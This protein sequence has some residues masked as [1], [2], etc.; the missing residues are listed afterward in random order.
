MKG[1]EILRVC[2]KCLSQ[3]SL[4]E[5]YK[6]KKG[7]GGFSSHC[8]QCQKNYRRNPPKRQHLYNLKYYYGIGENEYDR[9]YD[10]QKGKCAICGI[11]QSKTKRALNV[12]HNHKTKKVRGLL[13]TK[14]NTS[15][16]GLEGDD[17]IQLLLKAVVYIK[18][19]I[20]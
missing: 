3:K 2:S 18:R 19:N 10:K 5:F 1:Q 16:G 6:N 14:C 12:D 20:I 7:L 13:C 15:I 8:K 9:L 11:H 4:L 17:G